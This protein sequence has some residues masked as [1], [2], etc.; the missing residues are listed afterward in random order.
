M[1]CVILFCVK[2]KKNTSL[3]FAGLSQR[4][5]KVKYLVLNYSFLLIDSPQS[6]TVGV[7]NIDVL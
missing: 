2:N 3:S 7:G 4:L 5:A 1:K 6:D